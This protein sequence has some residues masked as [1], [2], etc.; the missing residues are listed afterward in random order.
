MK[1][2]WR[3]LRRS[4]IPFKWEQKYVAYLHFKYYQNLRKHEGTHSL[5]PFDQHKCVFI[6]IPK[7]GGM[8]VSNSLFGK[9]RML[10]GHYSVDFYQVVFGDD[11]DQYTKFA[12]SRNPWDRL[13]SAYH[14]LKGGGMDFRDK[15][16]EQK[17]IKEYKNFKDF[18]NEW[19]DQKNIYK[20]MHFTPQSDFVC[21][22]NGKLLVNYVGQCEN[23]Q[24]AFEE[25]T[26]MLGIE[27][28]S[29][30]HINRSS[31]AQDY[32]QYFREKEAARVAEVYKQDIELFGYEF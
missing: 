30:A 5:Q 1:N 28:K 2:T 31:R 15:E 3:K 26:G 8:A 18:V 27:G 24:E 17:H 20:G 11:F 14:Y 22:K 10:G 4:L 16:W 19:V 6:H 12:I 21:D 23:M 32:R 9:N 29:L 25:I 7:N 13:V